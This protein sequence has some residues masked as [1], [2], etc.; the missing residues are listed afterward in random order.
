MSKPNLADIMTRLGKSKVKLVVDVLEKYGLQ[1]VPRV[2]DTDSITIASFDV[3]K[4]CE[5]E[6]QALGFLVMKIELSIGDTKR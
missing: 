1:D 6:L 5:K 3:P 4:E 2:M